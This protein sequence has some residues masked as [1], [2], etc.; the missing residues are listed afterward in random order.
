MLDSFVE[1]HSKPQDNIVQKSL[2]HQSLRQSFKREKSKRP[3]K[4]FQGVK[5]TILHRW[6]TFEK[7]EKKVEEDP[8]LFMKRTKEKIDELQKELDKV[9]M[10]FLKFAS[11]NSLEGDRDVGEKMDFDSEGEVPQISSASRYE[12]NGELVESHSAINLSFSSDNNPNIRNCN[13]EEKVPE[14]S[15][16]FWHEG[17]RE[18]IKSY[19][20]RNLSIDMFDLN[21]MNM[22]QE[23]GSRKPPC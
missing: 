3:S 15:V 4:I 5:D 8:I 9:Q 18:V 23:Q 10:D 7:S 13:E 22:G 1:K 2:T 12:G 20:S 17:S 16:I 14:A 11:L 21:L 6:S 19:S